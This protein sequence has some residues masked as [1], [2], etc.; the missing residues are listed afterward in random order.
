MPLKFSDETFELIG[1]ITI[2]IGSIITIIIIALHKKKHN[3]LYNSSV[4]R[5]SQI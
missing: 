3:Q 1:L 2:I 4:N 5:D